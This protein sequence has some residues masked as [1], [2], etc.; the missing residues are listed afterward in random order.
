MSLG[1]LI[2]EKHIQVLGRRVVSEK[3]AAM[4]LCARAK[5]QQAQQWKSANRRERREAGGR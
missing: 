4:V 3:A 5:V 2:Y 1:S